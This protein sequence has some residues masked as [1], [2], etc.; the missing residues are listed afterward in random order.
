M[1]DIPVVKLPDDEDIRVR[2]E[3]VRAEL[4]DVKMPELPNVEDATTG[5]SP[6]LTHLDQQFEELDQ[7]VTESKTK[8]EGVQAAKQKLQLSD[9]QSSRGL[10]LGL[11]IAYMI[12]GLPLAGVAIG[13]LI[14]RQLHTNSWKGILTVVGL[15]IGITMTVLYQNR[16]NKKD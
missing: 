4:A 11:A 10:G 6:D 16:L 14:D 7:R 3:R 5:R 15:G 8:R 13:W 12:I 2:F 9:Q 1:D